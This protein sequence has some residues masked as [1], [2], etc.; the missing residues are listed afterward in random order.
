MPVCQTCGVL[1]DSHRISCG[2]CGTT[3]PSEPSAP[4]SYESVP[5]GARSA[6]PSSGIAP[7][8]TANSP[9]LGARRAIWLAG[10]G[11]LGGAIG[12][13]LGELTNPER[14]TMTI[15][16]SLWWVGIWFAII[17]ACIA[18]GISAG[19]LAYLKQ[20]AV[21]PASIASGA[22]G[23][24]AGFIGGAIAQGIYMIIGHNLLFQDIC[25]GIA[26]A[27]VGLALSVRIPNLSKIRGLIGGFL[28]GIVGCGMFYVVSA[29]AT[30]A[31]GRPIG[32]AAIGFAI[33]LMIVVS[34]SLFREAWLEI[35][36]GPKESRTV[37]L[38]R[39]PICVGSDVSR[40]AV[41]VSG[42]G[43]VARRYVLRF[44][45]ITCEDPSTGRKRT[46]RPGD[47]ETLGNVT[48]IVRGS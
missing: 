11:A 8:V 41:F 22:F 31:I 20:K 21:Q 43:A 40:C 24:A 10:W 44:R 17:T 14:Q 3:I 19:Q 34:E 15:L 36:Y 29:L 37:S 23:F 38:G 25:W 42:M 18:C 7:A 9:N 48:V 6:S 46:A 4:P 35:Q 1:N 30:A 26:G 16:T 39:T 27:L 2:V 33:G 28:G 5:T 45:V 13:L 47:T 12:G 32:C